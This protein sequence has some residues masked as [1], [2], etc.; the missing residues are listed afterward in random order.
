MVRQVGVE[1]LICT[2]GNVAD[3]QI[4][5]FG[6]IALAD[7]L[8]WDAEHPNIVPVLEIMFQNPCGQDLLFKGRDPGLGISVQQFPDD[9]PV[10]RTGLQN[11]PWGKVGYPCQKIHHGPDY[12]HWGIERV[13]GTLFQAVHKGIR[14]R[15]A[16]ILVQ[17]T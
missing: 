8:K 17:C 3:D 11:G 15:I 7:T 6:G 5:T 2:K 4:I 10:P 12:G 13:Q 9:Q 1:D 14:I 16:N